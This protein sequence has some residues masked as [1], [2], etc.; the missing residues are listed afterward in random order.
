[1]STIESGQIHAATL[2]APRDIRVESRPL[3]RAQPG[4]VVLAVE[5]AGICGTDVAV[6]EGH[7]PANLPV[8]LGHEFA[9]RIVEIGQGVDKLQL[10]QVV[11]A[12]GSWQADVNGRRD[13]PHAG[14]LGRTA[15]GCFADAV[16]VPAKAIYALP[17]NVSPMVA[18]SATTLATAVHAVERSGDLAGKNVAI[19]GPGHAGL[20]LLQVCRL[21]GAGRIVVYGTRLERLEIARTLGAD[22]VINVHQ[23]NSADR[24]TLITQE[25]FDCVF[26]AS[27]K[28]AGLA[29]AMSAARQGGTVV[30]YGILDG[31]LNDVSGLPLYAKEL[32][33][34][35][36]KGA[37]GRYSQA[38]ELLESERVRVEPLI[39]HVL[40]F[41][42]CAQGF[43]LV[44]DR[45]ARAL[46]IVMTPIR[47]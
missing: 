35:G 29:L 10:G 6:F 17:P 16:A 3:P 39:S 41:E 1:M 15:D 30:A 47:R 8:V 2:Y 43:A 38:L 5:A 46:R 31:P 40:T 37:G 14:A 4:W 20:L 22:E 42:E 33:I 18:Q 13:V 44:R 9:G 7:H 19:I 27:G 34:V 23:S 36:S 24:E 32:S 45:Q 25:D 26:E 28:A 12:A 11:M 21:A